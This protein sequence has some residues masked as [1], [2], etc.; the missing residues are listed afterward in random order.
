MSC[1]KVSVELHRGGKRHKFA[2]LE[3]TDAQCYEDCS[4]Q[5]SNNLVKSGRMAADA[6]FGGK[7]AT[8]PPISLTW[9]VKDGSG[10]TVH[11]TISKGPAGPTD[12]D[13]PAVLALFDSCCGHPKVQGF[14]KTKG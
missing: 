2:N 6:Y 14:V 9:T 3:C 11:E 4:Q 8:G 7:G 1:L 5:F 12:A 10:N 13:L